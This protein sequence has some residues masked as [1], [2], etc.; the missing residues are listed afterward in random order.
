MWT[1]DTAYDKFMGRFSTR[2]APVFADFAGIERLARSM[3]APARAR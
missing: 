1:S 3:S 2:L